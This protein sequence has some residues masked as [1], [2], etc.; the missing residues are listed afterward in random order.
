M[1]ASIGE[2]L[3]LLAQVAGV[4]LRGLDDEQLDIVA[5]R[6][7]IECDDQPVLSC[8]RRIV[9]EV[10]QAK[11]V[12][13]RCLADEREARQRLIESHTAEDAR[14]GVHP[15]PRRPGFVR[16]PEAGERSDDRRVSSR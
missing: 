2:S 8:I 16:V 13:E 4:P 14:T 7:V 3:T 6:L 1:T 11:E 15:V 10:R 5:L 9:D 12:A